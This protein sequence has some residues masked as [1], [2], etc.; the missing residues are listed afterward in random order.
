MNNTNINFGFQDQSFCDI[1]NNLAI[2][3]GNK[4]TLDNINQFVLTMKL[5]GN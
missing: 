3:C 4:E 5:C 1:S 2:K